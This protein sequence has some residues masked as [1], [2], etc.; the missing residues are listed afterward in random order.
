M[1]AIIMTGNSLEE[2]WCS[3]SPAIRASRILEIQKALFQIRSSGASVPDWFYNIFRNSDQAY[4]DKVATLYKGL[5][6]R[7]GR[8]I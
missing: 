7:K 2:K 3:L 1:K 8:A 5:D 4:E 6:K